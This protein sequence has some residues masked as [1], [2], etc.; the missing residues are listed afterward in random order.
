MDHILTIKQIAHIQKI[1]AD[2]PTYASDNP[3]EPIDPITYRNSDGDAL[4]HIAAA[5]GDVDTVCTLLSVGVDPNLKG[6][7]G[8]TPFHYARD[9]GKVDVIAALI[10]FGANTNQKTEFDDM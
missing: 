10:Q 9:A 3:F 7:M 4:I 1:Y 5:R 2:L 6:D 8:Y